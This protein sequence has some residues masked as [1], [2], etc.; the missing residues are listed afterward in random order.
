MNPALIILNPRNI[1]ECMASYQTLDIPRCY[2]TGYTEPGL[3]APFA[4]A[5]AESDYTHYLVQCDDVVATQDALDKVLGLLEAGHPVVTGYCNLDAGSTDVNI[6]K[7]PVGSP[8]AFYYQWYSRAEADGWMS[9]AIPT[10]FVGLCFTGTTRQN[11][12]DVRMHPYRELGYAT[13]AR[14]SRFFQ[15]SQIPMVAATGAFCFHVKETWNKLDQEPRK[16]LLVGEVKPEIR[17]ER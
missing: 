8:G 11:W 13:D 15:H 9:A 12:L 3:E 4:Q 1:E 7:E 14:L 16:R 10:W 5:I 6:T 17:W 2:L